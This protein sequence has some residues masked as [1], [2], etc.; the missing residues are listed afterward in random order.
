MSSEKFDKISIGIPTY[1]RPQ[2]L[3]LKLEW[4]LK[5]TYLNLEIVVSDNFSTDKKVKEVIEE[6]KIKDSRIVFFQQEENIGLVNNHQFVLDKANGD[7]FMWMAD[8]D[9]VEDLNFISILYNKIH[10]S[11]FDFVFPEC[12]YLN[13]DGS[14]ISALNHVYSNCNSKFDYLNGFTNSYSCLEFYG[15]YKMSKFKRPTEFIMNDGVVCFDLLYVSNLLLNHRVSFVPETYFLYNHVPSTDTFKRNLNLFI[16][17]QAVLRNLI[18]IFASTDVLK[19]NERAE[20][21]HN[22][23]LYYDLLLTKQLSVSKF[24]RKKIEVF[25]QVKHFLGRNKS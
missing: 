11:E 9:I 24:R 18:K 4:L 15:L 1:N 6:C 14:R 20:I 13:A 19:P 23:I 10:N 8:D 25:N 22:I 7:Y 12:Y 17:K 2:E 3:K 16:D 21:A 5:Q